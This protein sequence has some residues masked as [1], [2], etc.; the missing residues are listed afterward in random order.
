MPDD[1]ART[2]LGRLGVWSGELRDAG[3]P[4]AR[5]AAAA[6]GAQ[7]LHTLWIPGLDGRGAFDDV[8]HLLAAAPRATVALGVL[9]IWGQDPA[10]VAERVHALDGDFGPRTVIGFGV[11]NQH[12]AASAGQV[13][14]DPIAAMSGYLDALDGAAYPVPAARRLLGA[15]GPKMAGLAASRTAGLHPFLVTPEYTAATR[16]RLGPA[17]LI[18]P[19]QAAVFDTDPSRARAIARDRIGAFIGFPAYRTN[20]RHLGFA[21]ADLAPGGSDR[22]IDA[23]VAHGTADN[24]RARIQ[25]HLDAG[26][27]HVAVH[28]LTGEGS[29]GALPTGQW[30]ELA[31]LRPALT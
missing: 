11:S 18:A 27:D 23:V 8:R 6:L 16:A 12:A 5:E 1:D 15:L 14:G 3:R 29:A 20:L 30:R 9:G 7:G 10:D 24:I 28:V 19:H 25:A 2:L 31:G 13:Y 21:E 4:Q 17:P 26:A 22:L